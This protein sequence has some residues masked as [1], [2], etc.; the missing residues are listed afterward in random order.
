[1][2]ELAGAACTFRPAALG[3]LRPG[4]DPAEL[5]DRGD[6]DL[7]V[8]D[9]DGM[10]ATITD[11]VEV[12]DQARRAAPFRL[13]EREDQNVGAAAILDQSRGMADHGDPLTFDGRRA[14]DCIAAKAL[15]GCRL[16]HIARIAIALQPTM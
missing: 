1:G 4:P 9:V 3:W 12:N 16:L 7:T 8:V 15:R 14:A 10:R 11:R 5:G 13:W 2:V 6:R